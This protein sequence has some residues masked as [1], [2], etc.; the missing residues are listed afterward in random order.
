M[1]TASQGSSAAHAG[2]PTGAAAAGQRAAGGRVGGSHRGGRP[3]DARSR[4]AG[5]E[6]ARPPAAARGAQVQLERDAA[7]RV[8]RRAVEL[9]D[10]ADAGSPHGGI[11]VTAL[12][13]AADE[14]GI[15][16]AEVLRAVA[17][18][19]LG[20]LDEQHSRSDRLLG[21]ADVV[22][23]RILPLPPAQALDRMDAWLRRDALRRTRQQAD[24]A[25]YRRRSDPAGSV[26]RATRG[27]QG[28][29]GLDRVRRVRVVVSDLEGGRT[30]V[31]LVVDAG[32]GRDAAAAAGVLAGSTG[33]ATAAANVA[34]DV[35]AWTWVA[36][37]ASVAAGVGAVA[38]RRAWV[39]GTAEELEALLDRAAA[40]EPPPGVLR[41]LRLRRR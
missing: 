6:A 40:G 14:L 12:V 1:A 9:V 34:V 23:T 5:S 21:P 31:G 25:E 41:S 18:E 3:V 35:P 27:V 24:W 36:L 8:L 39:G 17:E 13:E 15:D 30:L 26:L 7:E 20:L 16:A 33:V 28:D 2:P 22:A 19:R 4:A 38:A 37:P 11:S 32:V 29:R 10:A